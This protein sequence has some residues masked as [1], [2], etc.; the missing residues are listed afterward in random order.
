MLNSLSMGLKE[1]VEYTIS[2][3]TLSSD[4]P[5]MAMLIW[6]EPEKG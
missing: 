3:P 6:G 4:R 2:P 5:R 1:H